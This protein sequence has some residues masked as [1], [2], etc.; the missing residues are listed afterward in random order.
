MKYFITGIGTEIGKTLASA[1]LVEALNADYW[2]PIQAGELE[3]SDS[4]KVKDLISNPT[5]QFH[6]ESYRL[7]LPMSPHAA[8]HNDKINI[9]LSKCQLPNTSNSLIVEGAG[10]LLVPLNDKECII[11]LIEHLKL[12]VILISQHYLGSINHTLL[13]IEALQHR[14]IPIKGILFNGDEN[15][16]SERIILS[17]SK[18]NCLG[19]IPQLKTV[20][21]ANVKAVAD[22]IKNVF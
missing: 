16:D 12:E 20:E 3:Y 6:A 17:K 7:K 22:Q 10:G 15:R 2:K 8:A 18:L 4:Q 5:S 1:I 9:E 21:K 11:D 19:R 13:S 14:N